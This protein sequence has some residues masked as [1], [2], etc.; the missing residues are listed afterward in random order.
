MI[1]RQQAE[2]WIKENPLL[3]NKQE[4]QKFWVGL[5]EYLEDKGITIDDE[6]FDFL[7]QRKLVH[8]EPREVA[9]LKYLVDKYGCLSGKKVLDVGAGR[10]CALSKAIAGEGAKV[11]AM[12]TNIRIDGGILRKNKV[13]PIRNLFRCDEYS[14]NGVG[15]CIDNFD[16]IVGLEPCD[17]TEHIIRQSLNKGKPFDVS[18]CAQ[19]HRGLNGETFRT[20]EEWYEHLAKISREVSIVKRHC[21]FVATNSEE[22]QL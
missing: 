17:A 1:I 7:V 11:T 20:F 22:V 6:V 18:L 15:T 21:G 9:F 13:V 2:L 4:K 19:P 8:N 5:T 14:K 12:D 16:L 3:L 10:V